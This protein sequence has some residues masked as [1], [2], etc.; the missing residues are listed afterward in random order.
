MQGHDTPATGVQHPAGVRVYTD[1]SCKNAGTRR[2]AGWGIYCEECPALTAAA[3][4]YGGYQTASKGE[5]RAIV[6]VAERATVGVHIVTD[7]KYAMDMAMEIKAGG[8]SLREPARSFG[9]DS[10]SMPTRYS[11]SQRSSPTLVGRRLRRWVSVGRTGLATRRQTSKPER[12]LICTGTLLTRSGKPTNTLSCHQG[13]APHG[14]YLY[15]YVEAPKGDPG[16]EGAE[17]GHGG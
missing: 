4:L 17:G 3:P 12:G 16:Q 14:G 8:T 2:Y 13:A 6:E 1:G 5:V 7:S 10:K 15:T 9:R 11:P